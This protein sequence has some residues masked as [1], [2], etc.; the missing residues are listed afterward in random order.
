MVWQYLTNS[1]STQLNI[2][3]P[4]HCPSFILCCYH[5]T[6]LL[7]TF[8]CNCT[9]HDSRSDNFL[10]GSTI[11]SEAAITSQ[12]SCQFAVQSFIYHLLPTKHYLLDV[13]H[14]KSP[15]L[16]TCFNPLLHFTRLSPLANL[17]V[18]QILHLYFTCTFTIV[19]T[20]KHNLPSPPPKSRHM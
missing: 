7:S 10:P 19:S 16:S 1:L 17:S 9:I 5:N 14:V 2:P 8:H 12:T 18:S 11:Q 13:L 20:H 4:H 15:V 6:V 3:S